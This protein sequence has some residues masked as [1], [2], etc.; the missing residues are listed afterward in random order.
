MAQSQPII[1]V[2]F[3]FPVVAVVSIMGYIHLV[4]IIVHPPSLCPEQI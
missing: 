3:A 2:T 4:I 1:S